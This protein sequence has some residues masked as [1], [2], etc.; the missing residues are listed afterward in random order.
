MSLTECLVTISDNIILRAALPAWVWGNAASRE[1]LA[2]SGIAGA[3]WLGKRVQHL[4][5]AYEDMMVS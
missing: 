5:L 3:G 2:S 1:I 4:S